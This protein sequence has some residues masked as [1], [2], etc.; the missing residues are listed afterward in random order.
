[1]ELVMHPVKDKTAAI[2]PNKAVRIL[3]RVFLP[4]FPPGTSLELSLRK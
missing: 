3:I 1:V 4:D 2:V